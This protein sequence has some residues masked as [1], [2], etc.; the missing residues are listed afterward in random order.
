M[1]SFR[2]VRFM[3]GDGHR[4]MVHRYIN[5]ATYALLDAAGSTAAPRK[6]VYNQ[7]RPK[8]QVKLFYKAIRNQLRR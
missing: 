1:A 6:K 3:D 5:R 8:I 2:V 4:V 7:L